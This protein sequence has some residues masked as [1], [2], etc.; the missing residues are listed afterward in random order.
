MQPKFHHLGQALC[1][2]TSLLVGSTVLSTPSRAATFASSTAEFS[3]SD[4][5]QSPFETVTSTDTD[6]VARAIDG[7]VEADSDANASFKVVR[8]PFARN[9]FFNEASGE[10]VDYEGFAE[11]EASILGSFSVAA[12]STFSFDFSGFLKLLTEIDNIATESANAFGGI[13]FG[14]FDVTNPDVSPLEL[15]FFE[16]FGNLNTP[17]D[18]DFLEFNTS[19]FVAL[20]PLNRSTNFGGNEE[21]AIASITGSYRRYFER[22]TVITLFEIKQGAAT[23]NSQ[24]EQ[25]SVPEPSSIVALMA[26]VGSSIFYSGKAVSRSAR[27]RTSA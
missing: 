16:L 23:V 17:G 11:S 1:L 21:A 8:S 7:V 5:S 25:V 13:A 4:F 6:S 22:D 19:E 15:D 14:L 24:P 2:T 9:S 18:G 20:G 27:K 3:F 10:G 12:N 26:V